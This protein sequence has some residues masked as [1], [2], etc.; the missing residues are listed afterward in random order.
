MFDAIVQVYSVRYAIIENNDLGDA[1]SELRRIL[2]K[3]EVAAE[4]NRERK[5]Q[6]KK[7]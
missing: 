5:L 4:T 3:I 2:K 1:M 6:I 7:I